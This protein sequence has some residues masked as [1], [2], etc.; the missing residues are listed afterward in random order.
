MSENES[1]YEREREQTS[2]REGEEKGR[3]RSIDSIKAKLERNSPALRA[4]ISLCN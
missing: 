3:E 4:I 2:E 1:G